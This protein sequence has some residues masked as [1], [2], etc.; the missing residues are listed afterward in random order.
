ML[1]WDENFWWHLEA[2]ATEKPKKKFYKYNN[3]FKHF[4]F[5]FTFYLFIYLDP[6]K[7]SPLWVFID[8]QTV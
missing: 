1:I 3:L 4:L 6:T 8:Q 5:D 7:S 2:L